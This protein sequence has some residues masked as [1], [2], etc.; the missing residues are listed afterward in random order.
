M[1]VV[2]RSL[3]ALAILAALGL[4]GIG[5]Y[6]SGEILNVERPSEPDYEVEVLAVT[7]DTVTLEP[8]EESKA[9]GTFGIDAPEAY[10]RVGEILDADDDGV[11][12]RLTPIRGR[13]L[14]GD[15]VDVDGYG[16]P[17]DPAEAFDFEVTE[18]DI[19]GPLGEQP[20][21]YA[22][23]HPKRWAVIV[24]GRAARRNEC[25]R[26]LEILKRT[27]NFSTLCV[28]YRNDPAVPADPG[29]IYRQGE[30]EWTDVEPAVQHA[31][32]QGAE[33]VLLVGLSM[34]G[35]ITANLLRHSDLAPEVDGVI[36]DAPLLDWGPVIAA[37]AEDRGVPA[38]LVPIGM[39]A[40][41]WRAGID[42]ADLNQITHADEFTVPILLFH[43][44]GDETVPV[45]V[46]DRFAE[47]RPDLV[48]YERFRG[49][50]HVQA[51]NANRRRYERAVNRFVTRVTAP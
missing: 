42:Y 1:R 43:G 27:H 38:W 36:W 33:D 5:W 19:A 25:F 6:Y 24:H 28:T 22:P 2:A 45:S 13:L 17:Q 26:L 44:T 23:G 12:R 50:E 51:W 34:G 46:A 16:Y 47:Q 40:S 20:A 15:L 31:L 8:T 7:R 3:L 11:R 37:G 49:A 10:A 14:P 9:P 35:Q 41:E 29:N 39:Q 30:Q 21:W 48:T 18:I 4:A 32:D